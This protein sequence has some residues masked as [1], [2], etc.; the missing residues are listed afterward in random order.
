[1][2]F[3]YP[4]WNPQNDRVMHRFYQIIWIV[5]LKEQSKYYDCL[6]EAVILITSN[7]F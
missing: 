4:Y 1:M 2:R 3:R 6:T 5:Y 7:A